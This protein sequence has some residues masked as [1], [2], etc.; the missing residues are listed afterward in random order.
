MPAVRAQPPLDDGP[1]RP[2]VL[3]SSSSCLFGL[4][5]PQ[6]SECLPRQAS[7]SSLPAPPA[8]VTEHHSFAVVHASL[9]VPAGSSNSV[10][11]MV[12]PPASGSVTA[13]SSLPPLT[14]A[15]AISPIVLPALA[16]ELQHHPDKSFSQYLLSGFTDGFRVGFQPALVPQL[17]SASSNMRSALQNPQ[18]VNAYLAREA[19]LGRIAGPFPSP[20]VSPLHIS[21]FGVIP[22]RGRPGK[23]RLIVD[24]SFPAGHSINDGI[25]KEDFTLSYARVDDAVDFII[26]EGRGTLLAKI[27]IRDAYRLIPIHPEDRP[28]L[29]MS[30]NNNFYVDLALPFGLRSAPFIFNQFAEGWHWILQHNH[31]IRFLIHYLDDFLTAGAPDSHECQRHLDTIKGVASNLGIPLAAEKVEGP[32]TCLSFLG[33]E[34]DTLSLTAR[35]PND[36]LIALRELLLLW[37]DKRVCRRS[38]LESLLGHLH[39]AAKVVYPGR[40]FLRRLTDLLRGPRRPFHFIRLSREVRVDLRWWSTFLSDWNGVSFFTFPGWTQMSDLQV[41]TD[42]SGS[43]GYGAFLNGDWFAGHWLPSQVSASIAYKELFPIVL[44]AHI[45][46]SRWQGLRIQFL[47]DNRGVADA[48]SKRFC[49][50]SALGTLLRSLFLAAARHSFWVSA[51]HLPGRSNGIA[52]SLSRFQFQRFRRLAPQASPQPTPVP[53]QLIQQLSSPSSSN[54]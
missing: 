53:V 48:I 13:A 8:I 27:D 21:R 17:H 38:D 16:T 3:P 36:K 49:H 50:D 19:Q 52:D 6:D 28:L 46:G 12:S 44:A 14:P 9:G 24:L 25:N 11:P 22:K 10:S 34:L 37:S 42:A 5:E 51:A 45:W 18:V 4:P 20:P 43:I 29:G 26:G 40:P 23:W 32:S 7:R 2:D 41:A 15:S 1:L 31:D 47:C 39:H 30:W 54:A 35:L 33:I